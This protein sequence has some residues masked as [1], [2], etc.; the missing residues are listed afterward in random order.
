M[1]NFEQIVLLLIAGQGIL[2]SFA[3]ITSYF[4]KNYSNFFLGL[5]TAV[6]TLEVLNFWG[7]KVSYH[8]SD[9]P[10]PFW[11]LGSY[12][13]IPSALFLFVKTNTTTNFKITRKTFLLFIPA[14]IEIIIEFSSF[15]S[16]KN[17]VLTK[18]N[19]WIVFTEVLPVI[20]MI[21]VLIFFLLQILK[22]ENQIKQRE[23]KTSSYLTLKLYVIFFIFLIITVLW[24]LSSITTVPVFKYIIIFLLIFTF[25]I[26]YLGFFQPHFFDVPELLKIKSTNDFIKFNDKNE[27]LRLKLLFETDKIFTKPKLTIKDVAK[28][29]NLPPRYLSKIIN[30]Y[31]E[32]NFKNFVNTY[33][34][35]DV[36]EKIKNSETNKK[37]L[38]GIALDSGFNSKSSFNQ[39]FKEHTGK[40]PSN[41]LKNDY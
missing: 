23:I 28:E 39:I 37:T 12:L 30:S 34:V 6:I 19:I 29:L 36:I 8:S 3:L 5:I 35:N 33:R 20:L 2:I 9:N 4:K 14:L 21:L 7:M 16:S 26:G 17:Y 15:Y 31:H 27:L 13:I 32:T 41:Y 38:L 18:S 11:I 22:V 24:F 40:T 25:S 1:K 10:F